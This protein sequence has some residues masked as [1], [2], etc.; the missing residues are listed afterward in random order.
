MTF[1]MPV[2]TLSSHPRSNQDTLAVARGPIIYTAE[3]VDN[4]TISNVHPH[5]AGLGI[6]PI[7]VGEDEVVETDERIQ[8]IP[9]VGLSVPVYALNEYGSKGLWISD[10]GRTWTKLEERLHFVPWFAR[11]NKGGTG[12][13]R[14]CFTRI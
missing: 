11:G 13:V 9:V 3:S 2:R 7:P 5:F 8:D 10:R 12:Q 6:R 4:D 14:T 1:D